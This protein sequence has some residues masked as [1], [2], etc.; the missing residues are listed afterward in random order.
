MDDSTGAAAA[1]M[2]TLCAARRE[3]R[4]RLRLHFPRGDAPA[5]TPLLVARLDA[6]E[7]LSRDFRFEV[8]VLAARPD[9]GLG[10]MLGRQVTVELARED[11]TLRHFNGHVFEFR[12]VRNDAGWSHYA[13][14]LLPWLAFLRLRRTSRIFHGRSVEEQTAALLAG[15]DVADW[16]TERLPQEA[17]MTD[18]FQHEESDYNY[19]HRRW[20]E[21][22]WHYRWEHR[23]DGHTL[24]LCGDAA[25]SA[26]GIEGA[27][28]AIAWRG[29]GGLLAPGVTSFAAGRTL[30]A[31][32]YGASSFDFKAPRPARFE[33]PGVERQ[34][35]VPALEVHEWAGAYAF[36]DAAAGEAH[37]RRRMEEIEATAGRFE[38]AGNDARVQP[39]RWFRLAGHLD[40]AWSDGDGGA[41]DDEF[42][43]REVRHE[44][45]NNHPAAGHGAAEYRNAFVCQRRRV[46]WRPG[47]GFNSVQPRVHGVQTALV[48]GPAGEEV[49]TDGHGRVRVQFHWD[50]D[51]AFDE[52]SSAF[53]R[54]ASGWAGG[55]FGDVALPRVGEEVLVQWL[56]GDP[57][58]PIVTGRVHNARHD[59]AR[60][61]DTCALP[62]SRH[63]SGTRSREIGGS[64]GNQLRLDDTAGEISAQ[65]ASDHA[66][67]QLNLGHLT[68]PRGDE[69]AAVPRGEGFELRSDA[70]GAIRT[71][72][73]LLVSAW[74]RLEGTGGQLDAAEHL[75]L[76]QECLDLFRSLGEHAARHHG[77]PLDAAGQEKLR[78]DVQ[79]AAGGSNVD[80][81]A[82][83]GRPTLSLTAPEGVAI[84][85]GTTIA[86]HAA[87]S[88]DAVAVRHVQ[89]A[90]GG[91]YVVNAGDGVGL[92]A[93]QGGISAIAHHGAL[94]MQSQHGDAQVDSAQDIR[95]RAGGDVL[96]VGKCLSLV[97]EDGSFVRIGGGGI[98]LGSSGPIAQKASAFPHGGPATLAGEPPAFGQGRADQRF[99]LHYG[100][101]GGT[102]GA[103]AA[104]H[105]RYEITLGD[106]TVHTGTT[107]A[108]GRTT[109]LE[110][111]AMH[112]AGIRVFGD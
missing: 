58:R 23:A 107:D 41:G 39:G 93:H 66:A 54:V 100:S 10:A 27:D 106:G 64:R 8:G 108:E 30:V 94:L 89:H 70:G 56:D 45:T 46:P 44:A 87:G 48:V 1:A 104:A 26:P 111:D 2:E 61:A 14:T 109:L 7:G 79:A 73:S 24:V 13:M 76:M 52:R 95:L 36:A 9:I 96:L 43:V 11:G 22:G 75:A 16:R 74:K 42:L 90:A 20:E 103:V 3:A 49:H 110:S 6:F 112:I 33:V 34:G 62:A 47:R 82:E 80:P 35:S 63:L 15:C 28:G 77:L 53:V 98:T 60:F 85:S 31:T 86:S 5:G 29:E 92:F 17:P 81:K 69:G 99:R 83:G 38:A 65:L 97:A 51:G 18:A 12:F 71:A 88:I 91:R 68:Q 72:R 102:G 59:P 67:S 25:A 32:H 101:A 84:S 57:D 55:G 21:R 78:A 19:L 40:P 37:V 50:R 105:R 4:R